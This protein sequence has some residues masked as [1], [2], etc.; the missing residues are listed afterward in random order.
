MYPAGHARCANVD[1]DALL[2]HKFRSLAQHGVDDVEALYRR[3]SGLSEKTPGEI[4]SMYDFQIKGCVEN[5]T[6]E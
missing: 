4:A 6:G 5:V 3:F 2:T 1:L